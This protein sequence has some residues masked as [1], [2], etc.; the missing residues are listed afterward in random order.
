[1]KKFAVALFAAACCA[2]ACAS[3]KA[4]DFA[5]YLE[6][7]QQLKTMPTPARLSEPQGAA[8]LAVLGDRQRFLDSAPI[9]LDDLPTLAQV[10][11]ASMDIEM[12]YVEHGKTARLQAAANDSRERAALVAAAAKTYGQNSEEFQDEITL[13]RVFTYD[14][15]ARLAPLMADTFRFALAP[16]TR[17]TFNPDALRRFQD[18]L[19]FDYIGVLMLAHDTGLRQANIQRITK[20]M[21]DATPALVAALPLA[22]RKILLSFAAATPAKV[23]GQSA[24]DIAQILRALDDPTCDKLC[25]L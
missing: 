9:G 7:A 25:A 16:A 1:M 22:K 3:A 2:A 17:H 20:A 15:K 5:P 23:S 21:A 18:K 10:C 13:V 8:L 6:A 19:F 4:H 11:S 14:C 24:D 12:S